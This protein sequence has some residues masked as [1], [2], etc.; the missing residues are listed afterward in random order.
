MRKVD[1]YWVVVAFVFGAALM[2]FV[3]S[4]PE[5]RKRA[6]YHCESEEVCQE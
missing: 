4:D 6:Y 3:L 2:A 1:I 5:I